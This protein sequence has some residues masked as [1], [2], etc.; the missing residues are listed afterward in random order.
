MTAVIGSVKM[1]AKVL[2]MIR[3]QMMDAKCRNQR[4]LNPK[5]AG[6]HACIW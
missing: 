5:H 4:M 1:H 6:Y 2:N 3:Y